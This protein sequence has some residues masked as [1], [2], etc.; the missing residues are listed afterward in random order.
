MLEDEVGVASLV[1]LL[2]LA[3]DEGVEVEDALLNVV[4]VDDAG[5]DV[6]LV[7][8]MDVDVVVEEQD[9]ELVVDVVEVD[10]LQVEAR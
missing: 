2:L 3:V 10:G 4:E 7:L 5:V 1:V 8:V 6:V 9:V